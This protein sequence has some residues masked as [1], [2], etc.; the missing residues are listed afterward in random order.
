M[1]YRHFIWDWNGTLVD[2]LGITLDI[3]NSLLGS[4]GKQPISADWHRDV[5]ELPIIHYYRTIGVSVDEESL[6]RLDKTFHDAY[7]AGCAH[8][9]LF[10]DVAPALKR[11]HLAN[12]SHSILSA[13]PGDILSAHVKHFGIQDYFRSVLGREGKLAGSKVDAGRRLMTSLGLSRQET[14]I[15]GDTIYDHEV[16]VALGCDCALVSR[17]HQ[18]ARRLEA[19]NPHIVASTIEDVLDW[20]RLPLTPKSDGR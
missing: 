2:D 20:A 9:G 16:A 12:A 14:L 18:S 17:G 8:L 7:E 15:I 19:V 4:L 6:H 5:F 10:H 3:T 11:L 13:L 1:R